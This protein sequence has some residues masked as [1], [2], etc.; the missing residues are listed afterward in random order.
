M[1]EMLVN[2]LSKISF[3]IFFFYFW[4]KIFYQIS[5]IIIKPY[6][7]IKYSSWNTL[8]FHGNFYVNFCL[9]PKAFRLGKCV[10]PPHANTVMVGQKRKRG[11]P[12]LTQ[13]ALIVQP[14]KT[15]HSHLKHN[16]HKMMK[17]KIIWKHLWAKKYRTLQLIHR[18]Q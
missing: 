3:F 17:Q 9:I 5:K 12:A 4:K 7:I 6:C 16:L 1:L 8:I 2:R 10:F 13:Q 14:S 11:R 15:Q 18:L